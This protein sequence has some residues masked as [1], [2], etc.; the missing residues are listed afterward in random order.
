MARICVENSRILQVKVGNSNEKVFCKI[1]LHLLHM[2]ERLQ[3]NGNYN[4]RRINEQTRKRTKA[5]N[6]S[7]IKIHF[8]EICK[9]LRFRFVLFSCWCTSRM[10]GWTIN[11]F[12]CV[13]PK[14]LRTKKTV[15]RNQPIMRG[16]WKGWSL[17]DSLR[18][19]TQLS[20][21]RKTEANAALK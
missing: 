2:S 18:I 6:S 13:W 11:D 10:P 12:R 7:I 17:N 8:K 1:S 14:E 4:E 9:I 16:R 21:V 19:T 3:F 5:K 20:F 15:D